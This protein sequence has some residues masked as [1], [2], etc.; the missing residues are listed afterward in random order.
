MCFFSHF[1]ERKTEFLE[2]WLNDAIHPP[3]K[4]VLNPFSTWMGDR[5]FDNTPGVVD[6]LAFSPFKIRFQTS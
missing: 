2:S 5:P 1:F 6:F 4:P 3:Y